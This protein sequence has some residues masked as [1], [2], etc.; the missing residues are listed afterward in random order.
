MSGVVEKRFSERASCAGHDVV[1]S[2]LEVDMMDLLRKRS[3]DTLDGMSD[4]DGRRL[5]EEGMRLRSKA[6]TVAGSDL[7]NMAGIAWIA[8]VDLSVFWERRSEVGGR[9]SGVGAGSRL[10][11]RDGDDGQSR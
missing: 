10:G 6:V 3:G 9:A 1:S 11:R 8:R 5:D 7:N 2:D 4:V